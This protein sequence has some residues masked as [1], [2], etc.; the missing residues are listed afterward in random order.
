MPSTAAPCAWRRWQNS[1]IFGGK[2]GDRKTT[3]I[4]VRH[5]VRSNRPR[6]AVRITGIAGIAA[7]AIGRVA[8]SAAVD[9]TS[10]GARRRGALV[11]A[12][13][14][15]TVLTGCGSTPEPSASG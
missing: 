3:F 6:Q 2:C 1:H 13:M 8:Y 11:L 14:V 12:A 10:G 5:S 4:G 9:P 15:L 7:A